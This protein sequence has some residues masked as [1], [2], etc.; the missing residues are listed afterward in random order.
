MGNTKNVV[1]KRRFLQHR[2]RF[3]G[4]KRSGL[5]LLLVLLFLF[6]S[7]AADNGYDLWLKYTPVQDIK[8]RHHYRSVLTEVTV[9]GESETL[10]VIRSELNHGLAG[11]LNRKIRV[12][13][14]QDCQS[15]LFVATQENS[16]W[17]QSQIDS[18]AL[19][20]L[21]KEGFILR[22]AKGGK[23]SILILTANSE[24]GLL[25]GT[26]F[27]LRSMQTGI[28]FTDLGVASKPQIR[29]RMLNHWDNLDRTVERGYAGKSLW[30]WDELPETQDSRYRDYARANASI[31]INGTVL[32]NV[33]ANPV[34]LTAEYLRKVKALA[35]VFRPFGIRVYLSI[36]FSAPMQLS[37]K[38]QTADPLEPKVR[39]WWRLKADSIYALIPDFGGFLVKANS[40][41]QPGPQDYDRNHADGANMLAEALA[42]HG[43]T[44]QWRAFVYD[45]SVDA[46]RAKCAYKEFV[47]LDG[48]FLPNVMVQA[49]NGPIDFQPREPVQPLFGALKKTPLTLELQITQEYLG[50]STHLV[51]LAPMWRE[52]LD[53][54]T[55][56][57]GQG[58]T[59]ARI[60]DGSLLATEHSSVAGV[61]NIGDDRNWTGH[62]FAQ[63]NWYAF[64]RL[65]WD[66]SLSPKH[67]A[68]EWIRMSLSRDPEV[69]ETVTSMMLGSWEACVS[70]MTPLGLHHIMQRGFH[71]GP[72]P[73]Y[74]R[75]PRPDWTS[76][77]YHQAKPAGVGFNRTKT[78]SGATAQYHPKLRDSF[79]HLNNCP[80]KYLLWFHHVPWK[81]KLQSG[82][83]LWEGLCRHYYSGTRTVD[84]MAET[85]H[86]LSEQIDAEIHAHVQEKLK[87]QQIDSKIWRDT[88]LEYFHTFSG[89]PVKNPLKTAETK[90]P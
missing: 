24:I 18:S 9:P 76:T 17:I 86:G 32:N 54:D 75:A 14:T 7:V 31:G 81:Y 12:K 67:I 64:G 10:D 35:D 79:E 8:L 89:L 80:E 50:H 56:V 40:E 51:Y 25:Y 3:F 85:W 74:A 52:Y 87:Q 6:G 58:S 5:W 72:E 26:F 33:N 55:H 22:Q 82:N 43:G 59:L 28:N 53:F 16:S 71:Y 29:L 39:E 11:L 15:G 2:F 41:G 36:K 49:K 62:F 23:S 73:S 30:K 60:T 47:P 65:A 45:T 4:I 66:H 46:D 1:F 63:A 88:C 83:T 27:L 13:R 19:K 42:P 48:Q 68:G 44:V 70:Y 37:K 21:G 57:Q 90:D 84:Q 61:T 77:Y 69:V 34:F 78:G 20:S 38:A